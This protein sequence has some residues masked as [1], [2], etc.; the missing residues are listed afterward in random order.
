MPTLN[1]IQQIHDELGSANTLA[2]YLNALR[3]IGVLKCTSFVR[4]GHSEYHCLDD[5]I[6]VSEPVHET[7]VVSDKVDEKQFLTTMSLAAKGKI[8]YIEMSKK[9][10]ESGIE[11]WIFD[12]KDLT[13]VYISKAG[14]IVQ[15]ENV[16]NASV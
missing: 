15:K 1:Q 12:T 3:S 6:L 5:E 7:F 14:D 11:R 2:S 9:L 10:T 13:I 16:K 4:D 8:D